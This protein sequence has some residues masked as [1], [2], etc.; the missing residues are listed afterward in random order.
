MTV[1]TTL[2]ETPD[3]FVDAVVGY[4]TW[5]WYADEGIVTLESVFTAGVTWP[6]DKPLEME[7][8]CAQRGAPCTCG[9]YAWRDWHPVPDVLGLIHGE[10]ALWGI[11]H[12]HEFGYRA[13]YA[14][15]VAFY[16]AETMARTQRLRVELAALE[17]KVPLVHAPTT[18]NAA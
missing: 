7:C 14:K 8:L 18:R 12:E 15:P 16:V 13:E 5:K 10:V 1:R 4:R 2:V 3:G 17:Y 6:T 11:F 9:V